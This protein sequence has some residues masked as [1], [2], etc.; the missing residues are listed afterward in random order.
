[1][2]LGLFPDAQECA[3]VTEAFL[4]F[5]HPELQPCRDVVNFRG[6]FG[7]IP[8]VAPLPCEGPWIR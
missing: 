2:M 8:S 7:S 1:M 4:P 3:L 6:V 5:R